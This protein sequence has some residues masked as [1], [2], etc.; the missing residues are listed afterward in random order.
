MVASSLLPLRLEG[1]VARR[2]LARL[3]GPVDLELSGEGLTV[4]MGPNGSG[5]TSLLRLMHGL[6]R[7]VE[8]R[9]S[10]ALGDATARLRQAYVFQTPTML[11][12]R[13]QLR[14]R[15]TTAS[16]IWAVGP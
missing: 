9:V 1:A 15:V 12:R 3:V 4:V 14:K 5:K 8:G 6:E 10:W 2:R 16:P 11:R 7:A 13:R